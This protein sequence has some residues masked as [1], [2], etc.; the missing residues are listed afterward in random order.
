MVAG[1]NIIDLDFSMLENERVAICGG[2][3]IVGVANLTYDVG[4]QYV[5]AYTQS[6]TQSAN[7]VVNRAILFQT[8]FEYTQGGELK[9]LLDDK[10][11]DTVESNV[12]NS[13]NRLYP[14]EVITQSESSLG[15]TSTYSNLSNLNQAH[16]NVLHSHV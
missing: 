9:K 15:A 14:D 11:Y 10:Y 2:T 4:N 6:D 1:T 8:K 7:S 16:F 12:V 13:Y 3:A 5:N